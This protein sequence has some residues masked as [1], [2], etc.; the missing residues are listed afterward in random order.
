[1]KYIRTKDEDTA[2]EALNK[3][4]EYWLNHLPLSVNAG[5]RIVEVLEKEHKALNIIKDFISLEPHCIYGKSKR[6]LTPEE[7]ELLK[8]VL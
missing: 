6:N 7:Y 4:R 3:L 8:E 5:L 2:L 1:M